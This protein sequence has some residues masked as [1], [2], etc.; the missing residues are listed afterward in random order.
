MWGS[1]W[2]D[3][4]FARKVSQY[5]QDSFRQNKSSVIAAFDIYKYII[6]RCRAHCIL[7]PSVDQANQLCTPVQQHNAPSH[8]TSRSVSPCS[9]P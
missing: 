9:L 1:L 7:V 3:V 8:S 5:A 6:Q 2:G 4:V